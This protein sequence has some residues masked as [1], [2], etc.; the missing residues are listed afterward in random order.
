MIRLLPILLLLASCSASHKIKKSET[1]TL[2]SV[3]TYAR[4]TTHVTHEEKTSSNLQA[5]DVHIRIDY[6]DDPQTPADSALA[7]AITRPVDRRPVKTGNKFVDAL[8]DAVA[9]AGN[10]GRL[11]SIRIDIGKISDSSSTSSRR[12]SSAGKTKDSTGLHK[13]EQSDSKE[14]WRPYL[15][16]AIWVILFLVMLYVAY[17][18]RAKIKLFISKFIK[19]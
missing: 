9:A 8:Q 2:D 12:D 1:K 11:S 4:D 18:N 3:S 17:R 16:P 5:Q 13:V 14:V 19:I 15:W 10:S 7:V 6:K